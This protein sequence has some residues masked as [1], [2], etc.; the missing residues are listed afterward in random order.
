MSFHDR[1]YGYLDTHAIG[2]LTEQEWLGIARLGFGMSFP[3]QVADIIARNHILRLVQNRP[4]ASA[5]EMEQEMV[6]ALDEQIGRSGY[7]KEFFQRIDRITQLTDRISFEFCFERQ[8]EGKL[9]VFPRN[10]SDEEVELN[11]RIAGESITLDP[12]PLDVGEVS[13]Y[14]NAFREAG[15]PHKLDPVIVPFR[16][17]PGRTTDLGTDF[18]D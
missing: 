10:G 8:A 9:A 4:V 6:Q 11:Y 5:P 18:T 7:S 16:I 12:W 2:E 17:M 3:D 15:Y 1:A 14:L 13:G